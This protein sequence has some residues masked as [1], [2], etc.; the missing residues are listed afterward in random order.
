MVTMRQNNSLSLGCSDCILTTINTQAVWYVIC[1]MYPLH[2]AYPCNYA[3]LLTL[4]LFQ[5]HSDKSSMVWCIFADIFFILRDSHRWLC[6]APKIK[7]LIR[8][9]FIRSNFSSYSRTE[10][11][12]WIRASWKL[13]LWNLN[14]L[15][16]VKN[17]N[18]VSVSNGNRIGV[19]LFSYWED[20]HYAQ[21]QNSS[22]NLK[23]S[24]DWLENTKSD[25]RRLTH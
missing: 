12:K 23:N 8:N 21:H 7:P 20:Y 10:N 1:S 13:K 17:L 2:C 22:N 3:A 18:F 25:T 11:F 15:K 6:T 24:N 9:S 5:R 4:T 19:F 14:Q 16:S